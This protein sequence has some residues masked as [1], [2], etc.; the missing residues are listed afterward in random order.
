M[1][2]LKSFDYIFFACKSKHRFLNCAVATMLSVSFVLCQKVKF[3]VTPG[4]NKQYQK[5]IITKEEKKKEMLYETFYTISVSVY[6]YKTHC[7][8][9]IKHLKMKKF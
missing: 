8:F 5:E 3:G 2:Q 7:L 4:C 9:Q 1:A 6:T